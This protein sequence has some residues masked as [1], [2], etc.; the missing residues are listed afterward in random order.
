VYVSLNEKF[1]KNSLLCDIYIQHTVKCSISLSHLNTMEESE[2][3]GAQSP[4]RPPM[5]KPSSSSSRRLLHIKEENVVQLEPAGKSAS[6]VNA[7][8]DSNSPV[9]RDES[10]KITI[11]ESLKIT[12]SV[13]PPVVEEGVAA[14]VTEAAS[15]NPVEIVPN[16]KE[17]I[18][19]EAMST[20]P[21]NVGQSDGQSNVT[22]APPSA[23]VEL[24]SIELAST[25]PTPDATS[26]F[27]SNITTAAQPVAAL[28]A[29]PE[30]KELYDACERGVDSEVRVV[31][32]KG[33]SA[34]GYID[35]S[36][37]H[38]IFHISITHQ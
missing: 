22:P 1:P 23:P 10:V 26:L 9:V 36:S 12:R 29:P 38:H 24:P 14:V 30:H 3:S 19:R 34:E 18:V 5:E 11:D 2:H 4:S 32:K 27:H 6:P 20:I 37:K 7:E 33:A 21:L 13:E 17:D 25:T 35:R 28:R 16:K 15:T 8:N 31:L